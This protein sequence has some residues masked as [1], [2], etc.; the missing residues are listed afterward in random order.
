MS[1]NEAELAAVVEDLQRAIGA[2]LSGL[3][4]PSR[5]RVVVGLSNGPLLLLVPRGPVARFH[6]ISRRPKNPPRP[7]S[8]QGACRSRLRGRVEAITKVP[9][10]RIVRLAFTHG[11][12]EL[13]MTGRS[14]GL[15]LLDDTEVVAAYDGPAP[16]SLP[17]LAV[18]PERHDVI[19]FEGIE[20]SMDLGA[21]RFFTEVERDSR[22]RERRGMLERRLKRAIQRN[23]RLLGHLEDDLQRAE[24][25]PLHRKRADL[26]A[27]NLHRVQRG[28][29][30]AVFEDWETGQPVQID[31]DPS[32]PASDTLEQLYRRASRMER[33]AD[34]VLERMDAVEAE[35]V[36]LREGLQ[37][38]P[39]A[40]VDALHALEKR[41]P[42]AMAGPRG[43][44][45]ALPWSTWQGPGGERV[46]VG[47]NERGNRRLTFQV[48][49]G[50]DWWMHVRGR[51]GAHIILPMGR[52]QTPP[53]A[54]LL[55][56]AQITLIHAKVAEGDS[57][58]VQYARVRDVRAIP[59]E[60]AKVRIA[61]ERVLRV[62]REPAELVG[63]V[64]EE[65][66]AG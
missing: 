10:D 45:T 43:Q 15:W 55:A 63:W 60:G 24:E 22:A 20:G 57:A 39:T 27:A 26:L 48:A 19:R 12:L 23:Q 6:S 54:H 62:T 25:G 35:L 65:P 1:I 41:L 34:R 66:A 52:N 64:R 50:T 4:Q 47:R 2:P 56:A 17:P 59:G 51:P 5:D 28:A 30:T 14:G 7:F 46:L 53:L 42:P 36:A 37:E 3:W 61:D 9:A 16:P 32:R 18:R 29:S 8:F 44:D 38:L 21:R 40:D 58:D 11:A 13:R 33:V 31:L 49:K